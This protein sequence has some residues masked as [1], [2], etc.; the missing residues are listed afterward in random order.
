MYGCSRTGS[1][2]ILSEMGPRDVV[3]L[4]PYVIFQTGPLCMSDLVFLWMFSNW[5]PWILSKCVPI[6]VVRLGLYG[7]SWTGSVWM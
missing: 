6:Y 1:V 4:G 3:R 2:L 7:C 5:V